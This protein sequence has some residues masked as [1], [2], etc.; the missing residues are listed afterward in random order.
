[1]G[2]NSRARRAA[3][4]HDRRHEHRH[5]RHSGESS[6]AAGPRDVDRAVTT[7]L[8]QLRRHRLGAPAVGCAEALRPIPP[9]D[10]DRAAATVSLRIVDDL[11]A[12]GWTP[13]DFREI[14]RRRID[15]VGQSYVLDQ[16]AAVSAQYPRAALHPRWA[17]ALAQ[18]GASTWWRSER[19]HLAQ[20][21]SRHGLSRGDAVLQVFQALA[22]LSALPRLD[23]SMPPPGAATVDAGGTDDPRAAKMLARVRALLA[24]AESSDFPD[25]AE[26]LSAKAQELMT[27]H[28]L[29]GAV[30]DHAAGRTPTPAPRRIWLDA[31]YV[32]AK[33]LV[34]SAVAEANRC[35]TV[36]FERLGFVSVIGTGADLS[37]VELLSTSL[38]VQATRAM[39]R[40]DAPAPR[41]GQ[42]RTRSFRQSFLVAYAGRIG[43]RLTET[44]VAATA[45]V[46]RDERLLPVLAARSHAVQA[47]LHELHPH[48]IS[49]SVGVTN[50]AGWGAGRAAAD[51]A[52]LDVHD[53][54][55]GDRRAG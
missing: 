2:R 54:I 7:L 55:A 13:V 16:V 36:L 32:G 5:Q 39:L 34:V 17:A 15:R 44:T 3:K 51:L 6:F 33:S 49:K 28:A 38:L 23:V 10:L 19:P 41:Y 50:P 14:A 27:R 30:T 8:T 22:L 18:T 45:E 43:E 52:R 29:H 9:G 25:E 37:S 46:A 40:A 35:V 4:Q 53:M 21:A 31:P 12:G 42:N 26:A 47:K 24:K 20:W 11:V 1:M 48:L